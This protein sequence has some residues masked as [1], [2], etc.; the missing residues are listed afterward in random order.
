MT[1]G[2]D[3][4]TSN[5]QLSIWEEIKTIK[6]FASYV[7]LNT[8]IQWSTI[9]G[10]KALGYEDRLGTIAPGKKPGLVAIEKVEWTN[11]EPDI[12]ASLSRKLI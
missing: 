9:N 8:L 2:T 7:P 5:W 3:S 12:S 4:L 1:V 6:K 11:D 10:A